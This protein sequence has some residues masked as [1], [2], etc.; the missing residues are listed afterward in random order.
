MTAGHSNEKKG[1]VNIQN[2]AHPDTF[3]TGGVHSFEACDTGKELTR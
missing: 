1:N 2:K 3:F